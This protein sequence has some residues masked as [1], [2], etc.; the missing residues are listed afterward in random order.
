MPVIEVMYGRESKNKAA[1][2]C[3]G[4]T[5]QTYQARAFIK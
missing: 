5:G 3:A 1:A 4:G 2:N